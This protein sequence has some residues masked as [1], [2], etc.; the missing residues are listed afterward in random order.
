MKK[1]ASLIALS[2]S[3]IIGVFGYDILDTRVPVARKAAEVTS[4]ISQNIEEK[5]VFFEILISR[6]DEIYKEY[7][8]DKIQRAIVTYDED[9]C[10]KFISAFGSIIPDP[11]NREVRK[12]FVFNFKCA[13][14]GK[15]GH[16]Y[17]HSNNVHNLIDLNKAIHAETE[18]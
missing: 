1:I 6:E 12:Q 5:Y 18:R 3:L 11:N 14:L 17:H 9:G 13:N 2:L 7:T 4:E 16:I 10:L 15:G 8:I